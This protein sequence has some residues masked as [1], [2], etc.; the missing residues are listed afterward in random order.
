MKKE[1]CFYLGYIIKTVGIEGELAVFI[2]V[3]DPES[4]EVMESVF[5]DIDGKLVPFFIEEIT[6]KSTKG[7][8]LIKMEEVEDV[9]GA[10]HLCQRD[11]YLPLEYLPPLPDEQKFYYHD[12]AGYTV[13]DRAG[14][15][16]GIVREILDYPGNPVFSI[17]KAD[18][19]ILIPVADE[20]I[21]KINKDKKK[22][23][24]NPPEGLLD[25]YL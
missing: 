19:E 21:I 12:L 17:V 9:D 10:R 15:E 13:F 1:E 14:E 2:D 25:L 18:Q 4:Y 11:M 16:I 6:I 3:D 5:V 23:V 8:A 20:L 24:L 7:D 22:I